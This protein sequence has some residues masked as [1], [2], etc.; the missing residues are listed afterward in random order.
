MTFRMTFRW[1]LWCLNS[2][3]AMLIWDSND[4]MSLLSGGVW[5]NEVMIMMDKKLHLFNTTTTTQ[6][7][8]AHQ[9]YFGQ[10]YFL[11]LVYQHCFY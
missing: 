10:F 5:R 7:G 8:T 3:A 4:V 2:E 6:P 1:T 11:F 9:L